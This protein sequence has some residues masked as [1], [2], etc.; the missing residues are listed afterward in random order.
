MAGK[1][2]RIHDQTLVT[3]AAI[4]T[5]DQFANSFYAC[6]YLI[7][8]RMSRIRQRLRGYGE[9]AGDPQARL[10]QWLGTHQ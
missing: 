9:Y 4:K 5:K 1:N 6:V 10:L 2:A 3:Y 8:D 7:L